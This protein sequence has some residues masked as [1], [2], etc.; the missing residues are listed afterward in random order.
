MTKEN[1]TIYEHLKS[2]NMI[3]CFCKQPTTRKYVCSD[4]W[5]E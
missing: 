3:C 2:D 5:G 1:K 4:C